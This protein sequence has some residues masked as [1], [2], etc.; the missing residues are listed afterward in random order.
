MEPK[1]KTCGPW[2]VKF[3]RNVFLL[4]LGQRTA[5]LS[6]GS[7]ISSLKAAKSPEAR[8][9]L[10]VSRP[11]YHVQ[12]SLVRAYISETEVWQIR[13]PG[14]EQDVQHLLH[15]RQLSILS[16][17]DHNPTNAQIQIKLWAGL[18]GCSFC[19]ITAHCSELFCRFQMAA[20]R[21]F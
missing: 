9:G 16:Q 6:N 11:R 5:M 18:A 2:W 12:K 13:E 3:G 14:S 4:S 19:K 20:H 8:R 21:Q 10:A 1:P 17:P 15:R 7:L